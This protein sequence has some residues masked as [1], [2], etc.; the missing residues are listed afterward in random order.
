MLQVLALDGVRM[1]C[2]GCSSP[3]GCA[4]DCAWATWNW[5]LPHT[6]RF[7][8]LKRLAKWLLGGARREGGFPLHVNWPSDLRWMNERTWLA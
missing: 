6:T 3:L 4:I 8:F 1:R 7:G 5:D 2:S